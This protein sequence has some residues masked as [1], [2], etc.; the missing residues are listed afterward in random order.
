MTPVQIGTQAA[1]STRDYGLT[2]E[3]PGGATL[4]GTFTGSE[5]FTARLWAGDDRAS[6]AT[7]T[8]AWDSDL[9]SNPAGVAKPR[10]KLT[11]AESVVGDLTPGPYYVEVIINAGTDDVHVLPPGSWL[12]LTAAPGSAA[13]ATTHCT[14][15][16]VREVAP[17]ITSVVAKN[18]SLQID[19]AEQRNRAWTRLGD[20]IAARYAARY[21]NAHWYWPGMASTA[22]SPEAWMWA[23]LE[24]GALV[25]TGSRGA[26]VREILSLFTAY[27]TCRNLLGEAEPKVSYR[28]VAARFLAMAESLLSALVVDLD[29]ESGNVR[30]NLGVRSCR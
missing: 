30:L 3:G 6:A 13:V 22:D 4:L 24:A 19:L 9:A 2:M 12:E 15:D 27:Y 8:A 16:D 1:N 14:L 26:V 11:V 17:W 10:V 5:T 29:T 28:E 18:P 7:V 21:R 23:Q 25:T 20:I